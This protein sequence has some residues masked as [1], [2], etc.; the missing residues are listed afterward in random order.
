MASMTATASSVHASSAVYGVID[1]ARV[2]RGDGVALAACSGQV[3]GLSPRRFQVETATTWK[4]RLDQCRD[5]SRGTPE[6]R[7]ARP[8]PCTSSK[9]ADPRQG[10]RGP[11]R[12]AERRRY[13]RSACACH[14]Q[15]HRRG[16][17]PSGARPAWPCGFV[18][19]ARACWFAPLAR[20]CPRR[21]RLVLRM[22]CLPNWFSCACHGRPPARCARYG[23]RERCSQSRLLQVQ[24]HCSQIG[25]GKS[26]TCLGY[27]SPSGCARSTLIMSETW[28]T[29][30]SRAELTSV[31]IAVADRDGL[32]AVGR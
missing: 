3:R 28:R 20:P 12:R 23:L 7:R 14:R 25:G 8:V 1:A 6:P 18:P 32:D 30:R 17:Q 15:G 29:A 4:P 13:A 27:Q 22:L 16:Q 9:S 31:A 21:P 19:L 24:D 5:E 10:R 2:R 11:R 26:L